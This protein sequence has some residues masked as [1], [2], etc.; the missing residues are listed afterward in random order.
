[1]LRYIIRLDDAC[2]RMNKD[3]WLLIEN[4][5]DKY[6]IK[7]LVGII[8]DNQ[9]TLFTWEEDPEFW[10]KTVRRWQEKGWTIA[11]HGYHHV[12]HPTNEGGKSEFIGLDHA[13]Q[14]KLI[15]KGYEAMCAHDCRPT[16]FFAPGHSFDKITVDVIRESGH[17]DF[18][19][20]G[21]ALYPFQEQ[22]M[23]FFPSIFDTPHKILPFGV[24][25][26]VFHPNFE[27]DHSLKKTEVF[28]AKHRKFFMPIS[29]VMKE[30]KLK[31]NR[32]WIEKAIYPSIK[33]IRNI[34]KKIR[35]T[36]W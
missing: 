15:E 5:L 35:G 20:D 25:T 11:Q 30:I 18:I 34:R 26:F 24:Y 21:Y 1:M 14:K 4:L 6:N 36:E 23:L 2:P 13:A 3:Q 22:G 9:D 33:M 17:F 29:T 7:P 19:S 12:Y 8:P 31:R 28:I 16:S 27:T 32:I 10:T